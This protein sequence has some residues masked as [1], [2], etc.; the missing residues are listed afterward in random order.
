[1]DISSLAI[2]EMRSMLARRQRI[3]QLDDAGRAAVWA[4][5]QVDLGQGAFV[6]HD[7]ADRHISAVPALIDRLAQHPLR[8][9][10]A[11][12]LTHALDLRA[13]TLV[14]ADRVLADAAAALGLAVI[15]FDGPG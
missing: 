1:V 9:L 15:R 6:R 14:T 10:D 2:A 4:A 7:I 13:R 5:F 8:T 3:G 11:F 12:H